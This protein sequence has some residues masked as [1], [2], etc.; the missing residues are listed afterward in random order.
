[1]DQDLSRRRDAAIAI[2]QNAGRIGADFFRRR[3]ELGVERK[4]HQDFVSIA[5]REVELAI[6]KQLS[7]AFPDDGIVGEEHAP[8]PGTSGFTWVIDPIDGTTNFLNGISGWTIVL[9]GVRDGKTVV[10]VIH[11]PNMDETFAAMRGGGAT[12]NGM[13]LSLGGSRGLSDG[14]VGVGYS[15][16]TSTEGI[17]RVIDALLDEGSMFYRNASGA[18]SLAYV[19]AGRLLGYVEEHMNA[20]DCIAGQ[21]IIEEAGGRVEP[22]DADDMILNGGRVVVGTPTV[23]PDLVRIA[24]AAFRG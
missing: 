15:N 20:W 21:L 3:H 24:D 22:Q 18:L 6:R 2:A 9:A 23:F 17:R 7:D 8:R 19:A 4:G 5:D 1:M 12:L 16:R 10:G 11:D 14:T 13:A